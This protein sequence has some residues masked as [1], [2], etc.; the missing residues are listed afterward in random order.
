MLSDDVLRGGAFNKSSSSDTGRAFEPTGMLM[1]PVYSDIT[2]H[3][4]LVGALV[5]T[6][7]L[8]D[9]L[10]GIVPKEAE[11]NVWVVLKTASGKFRYSYSY[12]FNG[13]EV[14]IYEITL[15]V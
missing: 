7:H 4:A 8:G 3:D 1:Y 10:E 11:E 14:G 12:E 2:K 13:S 15:R 6:V 5:A 9:F